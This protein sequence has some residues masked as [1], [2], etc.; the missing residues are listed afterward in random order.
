ML[1]NAENDPAKLASARTIKSVIDTYFI[2]ELGDKVIT[3]ITAADLNAYIKVRKA[4]WITGEG[5]MDK[6]IEYWR[7]SKKVVR[8]PNRVVPSHSTLKRLIPHPHQPFNISLWA[9]PG[10]SCSVAGKPVCK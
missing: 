9:R 10:H 1:E 7:G 6:F 3:A 4:Y 2:P 5:K 8:P